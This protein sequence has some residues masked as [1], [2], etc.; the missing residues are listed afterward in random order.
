MKPYRYGIPEKH[1]ERSGLMSFVR[2]DKRNQERK[3]FIEFFFDFLNLFDEF[4]QQLSDRLT[5]VRPAASTL[6]AMAMPASRSTRWRKEQVAIGGRLLAV[7]V[8]PGGPRRNVVWAGASRREAAL[9]EAYRRPGSGN[10]H[11]AWC[12]TAT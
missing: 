9:E 7:P 11:C 1:S 6:A 8:R 12:E 3:L 5:Q 2:L 4:G 10:G